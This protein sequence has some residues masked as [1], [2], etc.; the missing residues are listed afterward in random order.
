MLPRPTDRGK[1]R[2]HGGFGK[3]TGRGRRQHPITMAKRPPARVSTASRSIRRSQ[4]PRPT[5]PA[6]LL[7]PSHRH[8]CPATSP[9]V[10]LRHARSGHPGVSLSQAVGAAVMSHPLMGAQAAKVTGSLADVRTAQGATKPQL[11]VYAGSGGSYLGCYANS[12]A[13]SARSPFPEVLV[14]MPVSRC[15]SWSTTSVRQSL[16][17]RVASRSLMPSV[18]VWPI[19]R[20]TSGLEPPMPS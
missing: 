7:R 17:S 1:F 2:L 15:D 6:G 9:A 4:T 14:P 3:K 12:P 19:K 18:C 8:R 10:L 11:Q 16:T 13:S 20:K 5:W